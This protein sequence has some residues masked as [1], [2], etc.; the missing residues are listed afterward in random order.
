M[1]LRMGYC[2]NPWPTL[3][4]QGNESW[5]R[6]AAKPAGSTKLNDGAMRDETE[7]FCRRSKET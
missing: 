6:L 3:G 5:R 1:N 7:W 4:R 2:K